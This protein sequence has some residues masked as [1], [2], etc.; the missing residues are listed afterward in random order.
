V[1]VLYGSPEKRE[2][3]RSLVGDE[4]PTL[5]AQL[6][7]ERS[8]RRT[9]DTIRGNSATVGRDI[10]RKDLEGDTNVVQSIVQQ[11]PLRG[12]ADYVLRSGSG[13][14]QPTADALGPM[15]FSGD[16]PAMRNLLREIAEMDQRMRQR[17]AAMG[18]GAGSAAGAG[19]SLL[20]T[21]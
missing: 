16:G 1:K 12:A 8:I 7:R 3:L 14:A 20:T 9:D 19:G 21:D 4:F 17:A 11:G 13:V 18:A 6:V 10:A 5:E 2:I 15:L